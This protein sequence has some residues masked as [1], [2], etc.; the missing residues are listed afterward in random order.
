MARKQKRT[1]EVDNVRAYLEGVAKNLAD[2]L[3]G[4]QGPAWGTK[5]TEIEALCL[6]IREVLSEEFLNLAL[7]RQA[8]VHD[9]QTQEKFRA[10]PGCQRPLDWEDKQTQERILET[11]AGEAQWS[12]P[13]GY[14]RRCRRAFFPS[15]AQSGN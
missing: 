7:Q 4:P 8:A 6:D 1:K 12:E 9:Q 14:C 2:K 11:E 13:E 15:V 10:C 3:Y 5:L